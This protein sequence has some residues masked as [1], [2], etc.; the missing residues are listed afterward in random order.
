MLAGA[1]GE[2][3]RTSTRCV[4][5]KKQS[6]P[7]R[8]EPTPMQ[9]T[10]SLGSSHALQRSSLKCK[11]LARTPCALSS[12]SAHPNWAHAM[13]EAGSNFTPAA[14]LTP[15]RFCAVPWVECEVLRDTSQPYVE[16]H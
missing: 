16:P 8:S 11:V 2:H 4:H 1:D 3:E 9:T 14:K 13:R 15:R 5:A 10:V 6:E 12:G 7:N